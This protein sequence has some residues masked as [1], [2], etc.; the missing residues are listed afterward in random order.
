MKALPLAA[1]SVAH[2][3]WNLA[4]LSVAQRGADWVVKRAAPKDCS[5]AARWA[6]RWAAVKALPLAASSVEL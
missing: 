6:A 5:W 2:L 4:V 3:A 1:N